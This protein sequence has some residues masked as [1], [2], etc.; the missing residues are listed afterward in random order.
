[1]K[2]KRAALLVTALFFAPLADCLIF[3]PGVIRKVNVQV[4]KDVK[5]GQ[6]IAVTN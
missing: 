2:L 6:A 5:M 1:M 3:R 4:G